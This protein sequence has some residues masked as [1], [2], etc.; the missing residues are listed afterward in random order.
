VSLERRLL[1]LF[2]TVICGAGLAA[3]GSAA[4]SGGAATRPRIA[5]LLPDVEATRYD[6]F[7]VPL[8]SDK[9]QA[10]CPDCEIVHRNAAQLH[11]TQVFQADEA[12]DLG[13]QVMVIDPVDGKQAAAIVRKAKAKGVKVISYDRLIEKADVDYYI[14]F[15]N[16]NIG[17]LQATTLIQRLRRTGVN[18]GR[19]VM[20][21]GSDTDNNALLYNRGARSVFG[22]T[23][24]KMWP[25]PDYFT[26]DWNPA[27]AREFMAKQIPA[28]RLE[29]E[30]AGEETQLGFV[31]VYAANDGI[32]SA[33]IA[34]MRAAGI[35]DLP[36]VTGQDAELPAVQRI[37]T[38]DQYMTVQKDYRSEAEGAAELAVQLIHG[39]SP[40][41]KTKL[42][43][44]KRDVPSVFVG[45]TTITRDNLQSGVIDAGWYSLSEVCSDEFIGACAGAGLH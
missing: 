4:G 36:P 17:R 11:T 43:N 10:L 39:E 33:A 40:S 14:S 37:L 27:L 32:A 1:A 3:C 13:V 2:M 5:F 45:S 15:D 31:G 30:P 9:V 25:T 41:V 26:P 18:S 38:G 8:F 7:D 19:I 6:R 42:N 34:A 16:E 29:P 44:G 20:L 35:R 24:F 23:G 28:L 22:K 21:N 12:L